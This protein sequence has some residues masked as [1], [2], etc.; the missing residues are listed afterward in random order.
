MEMLYFRPIPVLLTVLR[1]F[2]TLAM[3]PG[4]KVVAYE[5]E[6]TKPFRNVMQ[7]FLT[8]TEHVHTFASP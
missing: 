1:I 8:R 2:R 4:I 7:E 3:H 6:T 5:H